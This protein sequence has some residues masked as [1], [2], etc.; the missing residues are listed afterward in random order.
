MTGPS[1]DQPLTMNSFQ[2]KHQQEVGQDQHDDSGMKNGVHTY[3]CTNIVIGD[4]RDKSG[5]AQAPCFF[6]PIFVLFSRLSA[7]EIHYPTGDGHVFSFL[8]L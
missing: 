1:K 3:M 5:F 6:P 7:S 2:S 8:D 4:R